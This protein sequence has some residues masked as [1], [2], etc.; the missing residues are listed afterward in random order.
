MSGR[1]AGRRQVVTF[2]LAEHLFAADVFE[3]E[4]VLTYREPRPV[5]EMPAWMAGLVEHAGQSVPVVDLRARFELP[6]APAGIERRILVLGAE[7]GRVGAV[8]DRVIDVTV[9]PPERW[10]AAPPLV[11]GLAADYLHGVVR[12]DGE[13]VMVLNARRLLAATERIV[14]EPAPAAGEARR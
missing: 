13:M 12:R 1:D 8:V 4:R 11:H 5:P 6:P 10:D 2:A 3:V 14:V 9:V 7:G